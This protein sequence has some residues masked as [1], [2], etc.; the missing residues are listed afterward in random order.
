MD[1]PLPIT[2]TDRIPQELFDHII[3]YLYTPTCALVCKAWLPS[4][5]FHLLSSPHDPSLG[6]E[7]IVIAQDNAQTLLELLASPLCTLRAY[8]R[9]VCI[10]PERM[11]LQQLAPPHLMD[12]E[13]LMVC[14]VSYGSPRDNMM[15]DWMAG[16]AHS[17]TEIVLVE[18]GSSLSW[19]FSGFC[20]R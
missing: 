17:L 11:R 8:L 5:R 6:F 20:W 18:A 19:S 12:I 14:P 3:T 10:R 15:I 1:T 4:A 16:Y 7:P 2:L 9:N 13:R